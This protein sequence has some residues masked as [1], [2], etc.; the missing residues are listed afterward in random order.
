MENAWKPI[1][2]APIGRAVEMGRW[3]K[4][5]YCDGPPQWLTE[6]GIARERT[7]LGGGRITSVAD[8]F[9]HWRELPEPP[10]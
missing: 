7:W 2:T 10:Q 9:S 4:S 5:T 1:E 6:S 3:H 8:R